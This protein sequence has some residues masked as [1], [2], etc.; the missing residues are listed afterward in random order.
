MQTTAEN[1]SAATTPEKTTNP[2]VEC[3]R[4]KD[5]LQV[6]IVG[7]GE[8]VSR[9]HL[10]VLLQ[11][12]EGQVSWITDV[13]HNSARSLGRSFDVPVRPL[14]EKLSELPPADVVLLAIPYGAREH[15]YAA[16]KERACAIYVE[17]PFARTAEEH[18][19]RCS[20]WA[21]FR[22]ACGVQRRSLTTV[23]LVQSLIRG[24]ML[25][26][27]EQIDFGLGGRG[28]LRSGTYSA[29]GLL[30]EIGVHG[31]D[32]LLF[33]TD[34][35]DVRLESASVVRVDD[36]DVHVDAAIRVRGPD[37]RWI[38][39]RVVVSGLEDTI[40]SFRCLF[41]HGELRFSIY[42]DNVAVEV[43]AGGQRYSLG[44]DRFGHV[45]TPYQCAYVY[46]KAFLE[47]V[48]SGK[49]N[50]TSAHDTLLTTRLVEE[51]YAQPFS[52]VP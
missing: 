18:R 22:I 34:A 51:I 39:G 11:L 23:R 45:A 52:T 25:G 19:S 12:P 30:F 10:P 3:T 13:N 20:E 48:R 32:A 28:Q 47:G 2:T 8:I 37:G 38:P 46:W 7:A 42:G 6:G 17:K 24:G 36:L 44:S 43:D 15:Y 9:M 41:Q 4:A 5:R 14:P 16:L 40:G 29:G 26:A 35:E 31:I 21:D 1:G 27:L 50:W 33:M 49:A